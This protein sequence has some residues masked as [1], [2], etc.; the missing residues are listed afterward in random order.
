MHG[1]APAEGCEGLFTIDASHLTFGRGALAEVG[2][3]AQGLGGK[4]VAVF[5]DARVATL[6]A[7]A[8]LLASLKSVGIDAVLWSETSVEPTD[9]SFLEGARF[10]AE[11]HFDGAVSLGGGSVIDTGARGWA[12]RGAPGPLERS[13]RAGRLPRGRCA[14]SVTSCMCSSIATGASPPKFQCN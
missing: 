10:Y 8:R 13:L 9:A 3:L 4:R 14:R 7:A 5:T 11:G 1:Y 12:P 6:P 2:A